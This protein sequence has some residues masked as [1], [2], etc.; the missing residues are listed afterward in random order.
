MDSDGVVQAGKPERHIYG[1][2]SKAQS[3]SLVTVFTQ[4]GMGWH[5]MRDLGNDNY[6]VFVIRC[7]VFDTSSH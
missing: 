4:L 1:W 2:E 7:L 3:C 5:G 6:R